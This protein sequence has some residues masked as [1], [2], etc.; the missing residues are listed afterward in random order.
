MV[1]LA[2]P[3]PLFF[4]HDSLFKGEYFIPEASPCVKE[5]PST[6][7]TCHAEVYNPSADLTP[8]TMYTCQTFV[9]TFHT[10]YFF[11]GSKTHSIETVSGIAPSPGSCQEWKHTLNAPNYG[12][13]TKI[14]G[15]QY[16]TTN[17]VKLEYQWP[18]SV[19]KSIYN[20]QITRA[21]GY[22]DP[23]RKRLR[24]PMGI[25][26]KCDVHHG[27]CTVGT[28]TYIWK[29][30]KLIDCPK[31]KPMGNHALTLHFSD[32]PRPYRLEIRELGMSIHSKSTCPPQTTACYSKDALCD[33]AGLIIVPTNCSAAA[34]LPS[35]GRIASRRRNG[36]P[37][38]NMINEVSDTMVESLRNM[39]SDV[40]YLECTVQ[41]LLSTLYTLVSRQYPGEALSEILG[42]RRAAITV[43]DL[44]TEI[45]CE[46]INGTIMLSLKH[47]K[48]FATRPLIRYRDATGKP[49]IGQLYRDGFVYASVKFVE[50]YNPG[51]VMSFKILDSFY[52]FENYTLSHVDPKINY[53]TPSLTPVQFQHETLDYESLMNEFPESAGGM[54]D[55]TSMLATLSQAKL[56]H[57]KFYHYLDSNSNP[58]ISAD[59]EYVS[60]TLDA[61]AKNIFLNVIS[62][63]TSPA[64]TC[65][66]MAA[67]TLACFW[68]VFL[69]MWVVK[70]YGAAIFFAVRGRVQGVPPPSPNAPAN[71]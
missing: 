69:T 43:G 53:V 18:T 12:P 54:D 6:V 4:C 64:W 45:T 49:R 11:F 30:P 44:M 7:K 3:V 9:S 48:L 20:A 51:R 27:F 55:L 66:I 39:T 2:G 10:T 41:S 19:T 47:H 35:D 37:T 58:T 5:I 50:K 59:M 26:S 65:V 29:V 24:S 22:Y 38:A 31:T 62:S 56:F 33:A 60:S 68:G 25:L 42:G 57:N 36:N 32:S 46:K 15:N 40:H 1:D 52:L 70:V 67:L 13:L 16:S 71:D 23:N 63:I 8:L 14:A 34:W 17:R 28:R 21:V 61:S